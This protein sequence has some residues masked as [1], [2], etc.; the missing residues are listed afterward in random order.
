MRV[1]LSIDIIYIALLVIHGFSALVGSGSTNGAI[2]EASPNDDKAVT[3]S[4][5][6]N[7]E[8][9]GI[10]P[11]CAIVVPEAKESTCD[12]RSCTA[13][14]WRGAFGQDVTH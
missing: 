12:T 8:H 4:D 9:K 6:A 1:I 7:S 3:P 2:G 14:R 5:S 10:R 13:D 11:V